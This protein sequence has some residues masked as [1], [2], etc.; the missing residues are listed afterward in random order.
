[1]AESNQ[2]LEVIADRA[3]NPAIRVPLAL[4]EKFL[5]M[6]RQT[7]VDFTVENDQPDTKI[8]RLTSAADHGRITAALD[9]FNCGHVRGE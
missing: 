2:R 8:V 9:R 6:V 1:M 4:L 5:E 7:G 3:G